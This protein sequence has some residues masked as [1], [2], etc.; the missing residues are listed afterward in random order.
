MLVCKDLFNL[1]II[2]IIA[3]QTTEIVTT[4]TFAQ[5]HS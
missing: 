5:I 4:T 1:E 3:R 2:Q